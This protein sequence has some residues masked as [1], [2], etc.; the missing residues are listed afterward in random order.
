M[1]GIGDRNQE[2]LITLKLVADQG[3][4]AIAKRGLPSC[5]QAACGRLLQPSASRFSF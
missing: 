3:N 2:V 5:G 1:S 4:A